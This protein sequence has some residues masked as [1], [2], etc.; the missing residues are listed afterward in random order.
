[1][2]IDLDIGV[3]TH[4]EAATTIDKASCRKY[5]IAEIGFGDGTKSGHSAA[6]NDAGKLCF[7]DVCRMDETPARIDGQTVEE[8]VDRPLATPCKAIL[9]LF[10]LFGDMDV[11]GPARRQGQD[12]F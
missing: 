12:R 1:G 2:S 11:D 4:A 6:L 7:G 3:R 9:D 8:E 5:S 10:D